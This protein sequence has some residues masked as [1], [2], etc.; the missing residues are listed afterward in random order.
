[1]PQQTTAGRLLTHLHRES[2]ML[3]DSII[4]AAGVPLDSAEAAMSSG[5]RL[6]LA[7]QLRLAEATIAAAPQHARLARTLRAQALAASS[8]NNGDVVCSRESPNAR[9]ER[10]GRLAR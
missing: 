4:M 2:A 10:V 3:R 7:E 9:W 6:S 1:M 8:Y 5:G